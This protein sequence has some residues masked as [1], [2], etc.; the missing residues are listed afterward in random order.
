MAE[1]QNSLNSE[2]WDQGFDGTDVNK[3]F[4]FFFENLKIFVSISHKK[5]KLRH[6]G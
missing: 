1:F 5:M 4:K 2:S 3:V 6:S